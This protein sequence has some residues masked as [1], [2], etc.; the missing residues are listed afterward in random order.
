MKEIKLRNGM[1]TIVSDED[2]D[3]LNQF[4]WGVISNGTHIYAARGTRKKGEKYTKILM[5][6]L[7]LGNP[8]KMVDHINGNTLD[9][10]RENLR[11]ADR[12]SNLR[13]S[14]LRKD[15]RFKY[16]GVGSKGSRYSSRIQIDENTRIYLGTFNTEEEAAKAY[17]KAAI[18]HF[19]QF[20][21]L[22]FEQNN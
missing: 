9:N 4:S 13:N 19:G 16:K 5:H 17:D 3:F 15:S 1:I 6:R 10:R 21:K 20:A 18:E 2:Y 7:I 11:T 8:C 12:S 14:K 22:N